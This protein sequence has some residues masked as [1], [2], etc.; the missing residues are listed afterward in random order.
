MQILQFESSLDFRRWL[1]KNHA[2]SD[3]FWLRFFKKASKAKSLTY[4]EALDQALCH[5]WIDG[6]MKSYDEQSWLQK[7]TP[8]RPR[9][10]WSKINTQHVERLVKDGFMTPA[11][12]AAAEAAK[13][14]GRWTAAYDSPRNASP[15]EDL[16]RELDKNEEAKAFF[17]GLNR[18]NVYSIVYRLQTARK[19]ETR[20]KRLKMILDMLAQG[21]TFH[22][23]TGASKHGQ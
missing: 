1:E 23:Q 7:F 2:G 9:S 11:G 17:K 12:L 21:K 8:R 10:G 16:L 5:G 15:P 6:Q 18:A 4:A 13:S 19:P 14:D 20:Q 22:P 3:G